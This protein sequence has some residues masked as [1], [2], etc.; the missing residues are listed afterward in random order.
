MI[1]LKEGSCRSMTEY[2]VGHLINRIVSYQGQ[3]HHKVKPIVLQMR[4][5]DGVQAEFK[6]TECPRVELTELPPCR[7]ESGTLTWALK[8]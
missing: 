5:A 3:Q 2:S 7:P 1:P 6:F 4:R 8:F